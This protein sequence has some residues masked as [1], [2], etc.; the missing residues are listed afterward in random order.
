MG[1]GTRVGQAAGVKHSH[2][3]GK[4]VGGR[5]QRAH[6]EERRQWGGRGADTSMGG[7]GAGSRRQC[8]RGSRHQIVGQV[9]G[10]N[11]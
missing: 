4:C 11:W 7:Q 6:G 5:Q 10:S 1:T 2:R 3:Q 8:N 9:V